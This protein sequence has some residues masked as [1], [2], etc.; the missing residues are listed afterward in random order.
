MQF[1][2][3]QCKIHVIVPSRNLSHVQICRIGIVGRCSDFIFLNPDCKYDLTVVFICF[4]H[5]LDACWRSRSDVF[6]IE[7]RFRKRQV[8]LDMGDA[9]VC[10]DGDDSVD[11]SIMI[12]FIYRR[13]CVCVC[14]CV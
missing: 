7:R 11:E 8:I 3:C 9:C 12:C 13:V 14:V 6:V 2:M 5:V 4:C 10:F 1:Q